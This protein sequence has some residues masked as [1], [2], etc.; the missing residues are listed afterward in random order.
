MVRSNVAIVTAGMQQDWRTI[1]H[2]AK[3][4][5]SAPA[6]ARILELAAGQDGLVLQYMPDE[7]QRSKPKVV[8]AALKHTGLALR[9]CAPEIKVILPLAKAFLGSNI[10]CAGA[11]TN[12]SMLLSSPSIQPYIVRTRKEGLTCVGERERARENSAQSRSVL[13]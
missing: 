5:R 11:T 13:C 6:I 4:L 1:Q 2:A 9:F 12:V 8:Q 10:Q 7:I 3:E